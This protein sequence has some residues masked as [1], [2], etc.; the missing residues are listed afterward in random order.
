MRLLHRV[1]PRRVHGRQCLH[2]SACR[3]RFHRGRH[4]PRVL[5]GCASTIHRC[6]ARSAQGEAV[7]V[8]WGSWDRCPPVSP[9]TLHQVHG[10]WAQRAKLRASSSL[11]LTHNE[12]S[13]RLLCIRT[14]PFRS[15]SSLCA[16]FTRHGTYAKTRRSRE[17]ANHG[18]I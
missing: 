18:R 10:Y 16:G 14:P 11:K 1:L 12:I 4:N 9:P 13:F 3:G 7:P 2:G 8:P 15:V 6:C 17:P 5:P